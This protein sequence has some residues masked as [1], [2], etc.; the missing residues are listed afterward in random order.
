MPD[1]SQAPQRWINQSVEQRLRELKEHQEN[2]FKDIRQNLDGLWREL[3]EEQRKG[4]VR[5]SSLAYFQERISEGRARFDALDKLLKDD[6]MMKDDFRPYR[7]GIVS[8]VVAVGMAV[9]T[10]ILNLVIKAK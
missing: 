5:A 1:E 3:R 2:Q 10:G 8:L 4:D 9:L 7:N 6:I